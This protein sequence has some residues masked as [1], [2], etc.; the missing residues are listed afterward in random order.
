MS[1][2]ATY[3]EATARPV[4]VAPSTSTALVPIVGDRGPRLA[5]AAEK[6]VNAHRLFYGLGYAGL[7][8]I[9]TGMWLQGFVGPGMEALTGIGAMFVGLGG[10]GIFIHTVYKPNERKVRHLLLAIASLALTVAAY[11]LVERISREIYATVAVSRL[12]PLAEAL[13]NDARIRNIGVFNRS[14]MLNGYIG[15][16]FGSGSI[17][18]REGVLLEEVLSRDGISHEEYLAYQRLLREMG[19]ERA[20]RTASTVAFYP[21]GPSGPW[22]LYVAPGHALPPA[23]ALLEDSGTYYSEPLGGPWFMVIHGRR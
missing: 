18:G 10:F 3:A 19:M 12:Q 21:D 22:L 8:L 17:E 23:H 16:E 5:P 14:V 11:P 9:W 6:P 7:V 15:A 4:A 13:A 1:T 20:Q 2:P